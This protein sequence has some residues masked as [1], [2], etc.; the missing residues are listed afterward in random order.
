MKEGW[1]C[2]HIY[3]KVQQQALIALEPSERA[4]GRAELIDILRP[5]GDYVPLH[6]RS[7]RSA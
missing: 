6:A 5:D 4:F 1:H 2:L 3:Y 7:N